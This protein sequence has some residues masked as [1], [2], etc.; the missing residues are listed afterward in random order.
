MLL[1]QRSTVQSSTSG[2]I[3]VEPD[4]LEKGFRERCSRCVLEWGRDRLGKCTA[5]RVP[6]GFCSSF[7]SRGRW[8]IPLWAGRSCWMRR[9]ISTALM[10]PE[11]APA[12]S[13][14]CVRICEVALAR[15]W[16]QKCSSVP[17]VSVLA[18]C[19][20]AVLLPSK[21]SAPC[22]ATVLQAAEEPCLPCVKFVRRSSRTFGWGFT[23]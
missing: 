15:S 20:W 4:S 2:L 17:S 12:E 14:G 21:T 6:L 13:R 8:Q 22:S 9:S 18:G 11:R 10:G 7:T 19:P 3:K 5:A 16:E 1:G 23:N